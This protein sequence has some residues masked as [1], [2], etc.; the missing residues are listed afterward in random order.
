M[1]TGRTSTVYFRVVRRAVTTTKECKTHVE[2]LQASAWSVLTASG[3]VFQDTAV[4]MLSFTCSCF[5][6]TSKTLDERGEKNISYKTCTMIGQ[7][8]MPF[9][10][11]DMRNQ[12][13]KSLLQRKRHIETELFVSLSVLR[14][15][16]VDHVVQN[17][18]RV[19]S[20]TWRERARNERFTTPGSCCGQNLKYKNFTSL[21]DRLRQKIAPKSVRHVVQ[22]DFSSFTK[23]FHL[24]VYG[25]CRRS[26]LF[27]NSQMAVFI[28]E[29]AISVW[30]NLGKHSL[31]VWL[32]VSSVK[33][34]TT[35]T[36]RF[37]E[38]SS[39]MRLERR[40]TEDSSSGWIM[41]LVPVFKLE[42]NN[43]CLPK[44]VQ[45]DNAS[46]SIKTANKYIKTLFYKLFEGR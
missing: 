17:R 8:D 38:L 20:L 30:T 41:R 35:R 37:D 25:R 13:Q 19:P 22:N 43:E 23:K 44:F 2:S 11:F 26:R 14:L 42:T 1:F 24:S 12:I 36:I 27:W 31:C 9:H 45:T 39:V 28:L 3:T 46:S 4:G 10:S 18:R 16:H 7:L 15:F 6:M 29:D 40:T 5:L 33:T 32:F 34:G 21:F